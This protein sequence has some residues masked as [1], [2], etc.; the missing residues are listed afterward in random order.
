LCLDEGRYLL[1][2]RSLGGL[3]RLVHPIQRVTRPS[4]GG[5]RPPMNG[6]SHR[7]PVSSTPNG[8]PRPENTHS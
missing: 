1:R 3:K 6:N 4:R 7:G 2:G 8:P 5:K